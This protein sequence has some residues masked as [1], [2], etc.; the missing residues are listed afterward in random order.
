MFFLTVVFGLFH[1]MVFLPIALSI[2]GPKPYDNDDVIYPMKQ[3]ENIEVP[4][5]ERVSTGDAKG[6]SR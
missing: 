3:T 1:G 2:I 4:K 6:M 5:I